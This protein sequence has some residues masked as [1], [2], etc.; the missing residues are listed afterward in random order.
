M[1]S[2]RGLTCRFGS[3]T[4]VDDLSLEVAQAPFVL[5]S[6]QCAGKSTTVKMLTGLLPPTAGDAF[7]DGLHI[8]RDSFALKHRI[9]VLPENL[10]LFD[11]LTVEEHLTLTGRIYGL[12]RGETQARTSQL[13]H[14]F[15]LEHGRHTFGSQCSY[16]M[17]KKTA[18]AMALLPN[19][20]F[21]FSTSR[22]RPSIP[23]RPKAIAT[24]LRMLPAA[25]PFS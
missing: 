13:L 15:S 24:C 6:A 17:R 5:L 18:L 25:S 19:P 9:G 16:G 7:V 4:A 21:Y 8:V 22:W 3:F 14:T 12:S 20:K 10:G 11:D 23:S 2:C 1:I